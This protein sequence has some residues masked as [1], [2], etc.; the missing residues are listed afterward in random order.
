MGCNS[1]PEIGFREFTERFFLGKIRKRIPKR[2]TIELTNRC[3][4]NCKHCYITHQGYDELDTHE[5]KHLLDQ[6]A[7]EACLGVVLTG[8]E[9]L[10]R[11]DFAEL[12]IYAKLKG[13]LITLFTNGTLIDK[14]IEV[15]KEYPP[16][17]CEV[18]IY[19]TTE[20]TYESVTGV[21]GSFR[22]CVQGIELLLKQGISVSLK[23][24]V[25][26]DNAHE[27]NQMRDMATRLGV[28]FGYD[29]LIN[30]RLNGSSE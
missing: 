25:M 22:Q 28:K 23:T 29:S 7:D 30:P 24:M 2:G 1:I 15:F 9:P 6:I 16:H 8:G 14:M 26:R 19:G 4:L 27:L 5:W 12:Y 17:S 13:L 18:S 11:K 3:N 21:R 20:A 10:F